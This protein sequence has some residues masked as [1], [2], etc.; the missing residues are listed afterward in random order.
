MPGTAFEFVSK[1]DLYQNWNKKDGAIVFW[2][3]LKAGVWAQAV[4]QWDAWAF[5]MSAFFDVA[6]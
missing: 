2:R 5:S 3:E 1:M 6:G 4:S